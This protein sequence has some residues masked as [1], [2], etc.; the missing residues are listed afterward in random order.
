MKRAYLANGYLTQTSL[1]KD[2]VLYVDTV[3][4][5]YLNNL[6]GTDY[7]YLVL[8]KVEIVKVIGFKFPNALLVVR[9]LE[10][11][12]RLLAV[13]DTRLEYTATAS[14][15]FD[16]VQFEGYKFSVSG[17]MH[18]VQGTLTYGLIKFVGLGG[19]E[20]EGSDTGG[21][22]IRDI[23]DNMGCLCG[24]TEAT[25]PPVIPI[26]LQPYRITDDRSIRITDDGSYRRYL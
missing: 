10:S 21:W 6:L 23:P 1:A 8:G 22:Y 17:S 14:E 3:T 16:A 12:P 13:A 4:Y 25:T 2:G 15:I 24:D 19:I 11:T 9:G 18:L 26:N 7:C 20:V 5:N